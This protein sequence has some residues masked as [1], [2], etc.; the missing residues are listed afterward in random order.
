MTATATCWRLLATEPRAGVRP[1]R[2]FVIGVRNKDSPDDITLKVTSQVSAVFYDG[3]V[4]DGEVSPVFY[5]PE[6]LRQG[7][8]RAA[9]TGAHKMGAIAH[10]K[11]ML[12]MLDGETPH[13]QEEVTRIVA[14]MLPTVYAHSS[15]QDNPYYVIHGK[16]V[17]ATGCTSPAA[18]EQRPALPADVQVGANGKPYPYERD[19]GEV[20]EDIIGNM[21]VDAFTDVVHT[22]DRVMCDP[23]FSGPASIGPLQILSS[24][25]C[26]C[27][28]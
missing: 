12:A 13:Q 27:A 3:E 11:R 15:Q 22:A 21:L 14:S 26:A 24:L 18:S 5:G 9:E 8:I 19:V 20:L 25:L 4:S 7:V 23:A 10:P 28:G 2:V 16:R 1:C 17:Q 6:A